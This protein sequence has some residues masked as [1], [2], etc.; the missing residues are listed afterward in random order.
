MGLRK[1]RNK[2]VISLEKI[3]ENENEREILEVIIRGEVYEV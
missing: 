3:E 1:L 2:K